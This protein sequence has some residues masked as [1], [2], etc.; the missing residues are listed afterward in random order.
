MI[1][2]AGREELPRLTALWQTCF[3]DPA[4]DSAPILTHPQIRTFAAYAGGKPVSMLCALPA[5]LVDA[6]G[7]EAPRAERIF[8]V[9]GRPDSAGLESIK[10]Y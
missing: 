8:Q 5:T 10:K 6:A 4:S 2:R 1:L 9:L 3:G 7:G